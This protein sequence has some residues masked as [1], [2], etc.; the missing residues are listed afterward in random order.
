MKIITKIQP[1]S[2]PETKRKR[3]AAYARVSKS[4]DRL[5]H[6]VSAQ[7]SYYSGLIQKNPE[8]EYAG[9][10]ADYF[11]SGTGTEKRH[12]FL[13]LLSDC[14]AGLIDIILCK[15]ISRF[16]RNTVDLLN[17]VRHLKEIG[18]E[19]RFEKENISTLS[20]DG[21]L[22]LSILASFAEEESRSISENVK[23]GIRK[24]FQSGEI[25][26]ANKHLLGY[27][28]DDEQ[29]KYIIIPEEA[30][31]IRW[32]FQMYL[33]GVPFRLMARTMNDAGIRSI[34]GNEFSEGTVRE[35]IFNE[36]YAGD[37][38]RQK[39]Y[40]E[41]PVMK[42]KVINRG[43]LP[44]YLITDCHEAI[45]DRETYTKVQAEMKRREGMLNPT[46][47][48][49]GKIR[50]EICGNVYT[51]KMQNNK[52]HTY[53]HWICRNKKEKGMTCASVNFRE[54]DLIRICSD[55]IGE[56]YE[57]RI[58]SISVAESG[59]I[60]FTLI[61]GEVRTWKCPPKPVR[62]PKPKKQNPRPKHLFDGMI[63]CG[64]CGRRFGR[65]ISQTNDGGHLYWRCRSKC[66][67]S[68]TCDSV[69]YTDSEIRDIFCK[70]FHEA[71]FSADSFTAAVSKIII[72]KTGSVDF[73]TTD[74]EIRQYRTLKLRES[75]HES[76]CTDSFTGKI[77]CAHCQNL[78]SRY[79]SK[80]KYT[81]WVCKGKRHT[82]TD[83]SAADISDYNLRRISAYVMGM[84]E[85]DSD[86]F[87]KEI[88]CI[89]ILENS[90]FQ[91]YFKDGRI[92]TWQ[93][94]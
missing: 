51:R 14:D 72:R 28:Y 68:Q 4:T 45:I 60:H 23:W 65:A 24:R 86:A 58:T 87:M 78:Y 19:V 56:D 35:I 59:D 41:D 84:D 89:T 69:N 20:K 7:V 88:E 52:G 29:Q 93:K 55:L 34:L 80:G 92:I 25:G 18:V 6:S 26:A 47:C 90:S 94:T 37:L 76:G 74:G 79:T 11:V 31:I 57:S 10:Y 61:G 22:M 44:Q 49:T 46:Y 81:Y 1:D 12:E 83:C 48:F 27:R 64:I 70:V 2:V 5:M 91:F 66:A 3:V 75:R 62:I 8:W 43:E 77:R 13:R 54:S 82:H 30:E 38:R 16:A 33:D 67:G 9:V 42:R 71:E 15:S 17:T 53:V 32:V 39:C 50:C 36:I 85:F 40:I 63:F 73:H 21:E